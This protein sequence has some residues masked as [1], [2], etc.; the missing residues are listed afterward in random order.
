MRFEMPD[1][2]APITLQEVQNVFYYGYYRPGEYEI[3]YQKLETLGLSNRFLE[4]EFG[5]NYTQ[6]VIE[7]RPKKGKRGNRIRI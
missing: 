7:Q 6:S 3:T 4:Y 1:A 5:N 2:T